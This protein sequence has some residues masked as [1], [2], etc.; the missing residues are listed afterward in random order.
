MKLKVFREREDRSCSESLSVGRGEVYKYILLLLIGRVTTFPF[1]YDDEKEPF[2][3]RTQAEIL[4]SWR[5]TLISARP[6]CH[7]S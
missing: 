2:A 7:A 6:D 4:A 5:L 3:S 1:F